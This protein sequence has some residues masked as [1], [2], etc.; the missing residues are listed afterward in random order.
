MIVH[1]E[2][3]FFLTKWYEDL[4][5][6]LW[7]R[8]VPRPGIWGSSGSYIAYT[9]DRYWLLG[10][11]IDG[12]LNQTLIMQQ[13]NEEGN[14]LID[15]SY[16]S[17]SGSVRDFCSDDTYTYLI[18]NNG[19]YRFDQSGNMLLLN[20]GEGYRIFRVD[21]QAPKIAITDYTNVLKFYIR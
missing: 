5:D 21:G 16:P 9:I 18:G 19:L 15:Q 13:Y 6:S 12:Q 4:T 20:T 10:K 3:V 8:V 17:Y 1:Q 7:H 14:L 11:E 2:E